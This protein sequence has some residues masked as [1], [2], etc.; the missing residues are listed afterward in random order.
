M[1]TKKSKEANIEKMRFPIGLTALL[2]TGSIVLASFSFTSSLERDSVVVSSEN[3]ADIQFIE[4]HEKVDPPEEQPP[5]QEI[6]LPPTVNIRI[7]SNKMDPPKP[8][9]TLPPPP[10]I[11][12]GPPKVV[13]PKIYEWVDV[14]ATFDP[15]KIVGDPTINKSTNP[16]VAMQSWIVKNVKYP[17]ASIEM[18]EQGRVYLAFVVEIDGS[19]SNIVIERGVSPDLDRE[20]KRLLR[21]M[22]KWVPGEAKGQKVRTRCRL[23]INFTLN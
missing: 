14:E 4:T 3:V 18:N 22:P 17:Q 16:A 20:A 7:D 5:Q 13:E 15:S 10:K 2:F 11:K 21:N 1:E 19:I 23:P 12:V 6:I 8:P 9:I